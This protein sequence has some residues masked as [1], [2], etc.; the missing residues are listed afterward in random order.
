MIR[1]H[2]IKWFQVKKSDLRITKNYR[3]IILTAIAAKLNALLLN[4]IQTEIAKILRK[5]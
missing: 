3:G 2:T 5:N 1:L 4:C